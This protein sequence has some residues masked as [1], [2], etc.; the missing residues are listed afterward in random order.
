MRGVDP[1][2]TSKLLQRIALACAVLAVASFAAPAASGDEADPATLGSYSL[3][4]AAHGGRIELDPNLTG[5]VPDSFATLDTGNIA[6]GRSSVAWPGPLGANAGDLIIL[7]SGGQIPPEMEP[8]F[9]AMNYPV[10]AEARAPGGPERSTFDRAPGTTMES[11]ASP[12]HAGSR[13]AV[14]STEIPG[15]GSLG[16][17][18]TTAGAVLEDGL[19]RSVS[20][21][22]VTGIEL[23]GGLIRIETITSRAE[24]TSDGVT[25]A[26]DAETTVAG[27]TV[28]G[29]PA[30][31][32]D[33][34]LRIGGDGE[35]TPVGRTAGEVA[36]QLLEQSGMQVV[37]TEPTIEQDGPTATAIA[38]SVLVAMSDEGPFIVFGGASASS[39]AGETYTLPTP[40]LSGTPPV[41]PAPGAGPSSSSVAAPPRTEPART[42]PSAAPTPA[43]TASGTG[44][45]VTPVA[46]ETETPLPGADFAGVLALGALL[47]FLTSRAMRRLAVGVDAAADCPLQGAP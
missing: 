35:A 6:Y 17:S 33:E 10:R 45:Q 43:A 2:R 13:T 44:V 14:R 9:R 25:G 46:A 41:A 19:A 15:L 11:T 28:A 36:A 27:V 38:G 30:T 31:L 18:A 42:A 3:R 4:A 8:T 5:T 23:G 16:T 24:A 39:L 20:S 26:G 21:S 29:T 40:D 7:A 47:A 12:T 37:V 34:G 1:G 32:D 22:T